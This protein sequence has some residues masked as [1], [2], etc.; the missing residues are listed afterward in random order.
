MNIYD[1]E[2]NDINGEK[3]KLERFKD[4]VMLIVNTASEW[5]LKSQFGELEELYQKYKDN[6]F[7]VLAFP[8]NQFKN[9]EPLSNEEI[10]YKYPTNYD[11]TYPIFEKLDVN[12]ENE[13][14]LY[15]YLKKEQ[16]GLLGSKKIKWNFTKFL[17]DKKGDVINRFAPTTKPK[18]IETNIK[19]LL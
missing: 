8:C 15:K 17:I 13:H 19:E 1:I 7:V 12:G 10:K 16:G 18:D 2:V 9:Q 3:L 4:H 6:G 14:P 11:I 5:G